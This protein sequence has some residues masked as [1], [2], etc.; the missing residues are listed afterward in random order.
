MNEYWPG[1]AARLSALS[2]LEMLAVATAIGYLLLAIRENIWCW[3]CAAVSTSCYVWLF[4]EARLYMESLLNGFYLA[5]AGY[6][7]YMW[8]F[9]GEY[10]RQLPVVTWP[11][12][13]HGAAVAGIAG[14]SGVSGYLL[15]SFSD[16]A[17]PYV[18]SATTWA[19]IWTTFLVARKVLENWWYWLVIDAVSAWIYWM[20]D[21]P[22]TTALFVLYLAMIPFG[23]VAWTRSYREARA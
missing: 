18:D 16:A 10:D 17:Y 22:L 15:A 4:V 11:T 19:A 7:W 8:R 14:L 6:G 20:R 21:L 5:M 9:G 3:A 12:A 13:W 2:P 1:L 23:L